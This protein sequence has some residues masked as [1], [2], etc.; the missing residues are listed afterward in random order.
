MTLLA[1]GQ[2][3]SGRFDG[4]VHGIIIHTYTVQVVA[5]DNVVFRA[6]ARGY[7]P[8]SLTLR[9][10]G[11]APAITIV[12]EQVGRVHLTVPQTGVYTVELIY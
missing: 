4:T 9:V 12:A 10:R 5:H 7:N 3:V 1:N 8:A 2:S 11:P 6:T